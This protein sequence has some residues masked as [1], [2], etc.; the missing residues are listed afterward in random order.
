MDETRDANGPTLNDREP[1]PVP[2]SQVTVKTTAT[3]CAVVL[4]AAAIAWLVLHSFIAIVLTIVATM[5]AMALNHV[6]DFLVARR[7]PHKLAVTVVMLGVVGAITGTVLLVAPTAVA[8][9]R[10]LTTRGPELWRSVQQTQTWK[11][12][13]RSLHVKER[14]DEMKEEKKDGLTKAAT[15]AVGGVF[16]GVAGLITVLFLVVFMLLYGAKVV[17]AVLQET[18]PAHREHYQRVLAKM[19]KSIAGYLNGLGVIAALNATL[20]A[21]F[22]A[23]MRV[24][25]FIPLALL[26][27]FGSLVPLI[28]ASASGLLIALV[29]LATRGPVAALAAVIFVVVYQQFENHVVVPLIYK[30]TVQVN[31]LITLLGIIFLAELAGVLGAFLAVPVIASV[32]IVIRELLLLRR[33]RLGLP[34]RGDVAKVKHQHRFPLWRRTREV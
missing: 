2:R 22:L 10:E 9:A 26:S 11:S 17:R 1:V 28:G 5:L 27:G 25:F 24:P 14:L 31:P 30:R 29:A 13:D 18:L 23:V 3:V 21:V 4:G 33:E 32:Q 8:Q 12:A 15:A 19:Y 16:M 20:M 34:L 7:W 6:V